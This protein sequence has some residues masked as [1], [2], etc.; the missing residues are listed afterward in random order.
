MVTEP[1]SARQF[2]ADHGLSQADIAREMG[3]LRQTLNRYLNGERT[4]PEKFWAQFD[5]AGDKLRKSLLIDQHPLIAFYVT[6]H[7]PQ[8]YFWPKVVSLDPV[9]FINDDCFGTKLLHLKNTWK[10][11]VVDFR[12]WN[13][14]CERCVEWWKSRWREHLLHLVEA[15]KM[16][17]GLTDLL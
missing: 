12:C 7:H 14:K 3:K 11:M 13:W 9:T 8:E 15:G 5:E 17:E 1:E 6:C 16:P 2:L 4:P 10:Y